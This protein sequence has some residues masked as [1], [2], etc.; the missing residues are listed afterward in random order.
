MSFRG[1]NAAALSIGADPGDDERTRWQKTAMV[2]SVW[3]GFGVV[4]SCSVLYLAYGEVL[5]ACLLLALGGLSGW[6][7]GRFA[8]GTLSFRDFQVTQS[9]LIFVLPAAVMFALGGLVNS[10][11]IVSWC[12]LAAVSTLVAGSTRQATYWFI[13]LLLL[14]PLAG[15]LQPWLRPVNGIPPGTRTVL[16]ALNLIGPA[17]FAFVVLRFAVARTEQLI[18]QLGAERAKSDALLLNVLPAGIA[19][20]L[21]DGPRTIADHREEVTVLFADITGF[22]PMSAQMSPDDLVEMLNEVFSE[23][24]RIVAR[25]GVEKIKTIGD[26]YMV[27]AG[28]PHPRADH[29]E[30]LTRVAVELRDLMQRRRFGGRQLALRIGLNSGPVVAGVIGTSKFSYDLWGDA[31][32]TASRMESHAAHGTIQITESTFARIRHAFACEAR[33]TVDVKGKGALKVWHVMHA[34]DA[35]PRIP[36][37]RRP[38]A[39]LSFASRS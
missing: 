24:D 16:A 12:L 20:A 7:L 32:N 2:A 15:L 11:M 31:V 23:F 26:C 37:S 22:T 33:G 21:R 5:A 3:C 36:T 39:D 30:V 13:A 25:W 10:S 1:L 27:A 4:A 18:D 35:M 8:R 6:S 14:V 19:A 34:L 9:T 28:V 29:A 38:F 17:A